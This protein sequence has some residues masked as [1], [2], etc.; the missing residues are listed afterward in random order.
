MLYY[1]KRLN[2]N[3]VIVED[4][5]HNEKICI[6]CGLGFQIVNGEAIDESKVEKVFSL[7][8]TMYH[9]LADILNDMPIEFI[10]LAMEILDYARIR[11]DNQINDTAIIALCDHI[12]MAVERKKEGIDV[13][14]VM[15]WDI[16]KFYRDEFSVGMFALQL[17]KEQFGVELT[18]DEAGFI[19]LH[20]VNSQLNLYKKTVKE[21]TTLMQEIEKIIR[22]H[23]AIAIDTESIY[24]Y[25]FI[26][27]LKFFAE[28]LF[29]NTIYANQDVDGLL[30]MIS[31]KYKDAYVCVNKITEFIKIKYQYE[32]NEE[33][34]LYLCIHIA[35]IVAVS[36]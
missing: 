35:R 20:I 3:A 8:E 21:V 4:D 33:E 1:K 31:L 26:T 22:V 7:N 28:R 15:L 17:I 24:Y 14:N 34:I 27:H 25:R 36:K 11:I 18:E 23:F 10:R 30:E 12:H 13:S 9:G 19:A 2:N 32:L 5:N 6:G 29:S 16:K